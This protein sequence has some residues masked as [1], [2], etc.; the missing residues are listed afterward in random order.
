MEKEERRTTKEGG[1]GNDVAGGG[2]GRNVRWWRWAVGRGFKLRFSWEERI[3][4]K[5]KG[6]G[7]R[8]SGPMSLY[9]VRGRETHMS[10]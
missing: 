3:E 6:G 10:V 4:K 1:K 5:R 7:R 2:S 9:L 8:R